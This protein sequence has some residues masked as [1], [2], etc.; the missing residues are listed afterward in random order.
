MRKI[1]V[2]IFR[3]IFGSFAEIALKRLHFLYI[4]YTGSNF[5]INNLDRKLE[6]YVDYDNGY[7]VEL[8]ANNGYSQSNSLYF[9][10]KRN[11]IGVLVEPSPDNFLLCKQIRSK[12]NHIF[13]N[14]CVS[15]DYQEKYVEMKYLNLMSFSQ[16]LDLVINKE[17][18]IEMGK[19][20]L[21]PKESSFNFDSPAATL[22]SLLIK[23]KAPQLIDFMSLDVEGAEFEVLKG[24][25]FNQYNFKYILIEVRDLKRMQEFLFPKGYVLEEKFSS[26][27]YLFKY[28]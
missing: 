18:H 13:C 28:S 20:N 26:L 14:A 15:F 16:N 4:K 22:N 27:D 8:G 24:I 10:L 19:K 3:F 9:E 11:W 17:S 5:S 21:K 1:L 23:A 6:N 2:L 12:K 25:N 7:F